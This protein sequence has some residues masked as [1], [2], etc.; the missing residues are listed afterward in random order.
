VFIPIVDQGGVLTFRGVSG[1]ADA[2]LITDPATIDADWPGAGN[3]IP[4]G[5][6]IFD[7]P[8]GLLEVPENGSMTLSFS[9][10]DV[11]AP[12]NGPILADSNL[13]DPLV[14]GPAAVPEPSTISLLAMAFVSMGFVGWKVMPC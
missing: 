10:D 13:L 7:N 14:P 1:L 2:T 4:P 12:V 11:G 5:K 8:A 9:F 3:V 6:S